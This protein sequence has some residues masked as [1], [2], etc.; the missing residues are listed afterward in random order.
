MKWEYY[1]VTMTTVRKLLYQQ[2]SCIRGQG[3]IARGRR[4]QNLEFLLLLAR[5]ILNNMKKIIQSKKWCSE[6]R[7]LVEYNLIT[8]VKQHPAR[9][10]IGDCSFWFQIQPW[11][12]WQSTFYSLFSLQR[13]SATLTSNSE[14]KKSCSTGDRTHVTLHFMQA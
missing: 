1:A 11:S 14:Q 2:V 5:Y 4:V 8:E 7:W 6:R 3:R 10:W 9:A 13:M 12:S